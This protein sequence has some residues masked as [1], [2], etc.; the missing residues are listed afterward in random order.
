MNRTCGLGRFTPLLF[1]DVSH[2][3]TADV[4][5]PKFAQLS[6]DPRVAEPRGL[7]DLDHELPQFPRLPLTPF[8][9]CRLGL[10]P[11]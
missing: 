5:E 10:T 8:G 6:D 9:A 2:R 3:L 7:R 11:V 4:F 1:P